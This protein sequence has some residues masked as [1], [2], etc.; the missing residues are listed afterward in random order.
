MGFESF[1]TRNKRFQENHSA[2]LFKSINDYEE[3][4]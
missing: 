2:D 3:K 1:K 4:V